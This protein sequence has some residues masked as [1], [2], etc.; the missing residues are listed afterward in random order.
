MFKENTM[1]QDTVGLYSTTQLPQ[2]LNTKKHQPIL[3][4]RKTAAVT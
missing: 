1:M 4:F 2:Q 3:I